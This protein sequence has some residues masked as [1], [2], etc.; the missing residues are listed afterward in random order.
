[1]GPT[2]LTTEEATAQLA[3]SPLLLFPQTQALLAQ[4]HARMARAEWRA[5]GAARV[6]H[7]LAALIREALFGAPN[8]ERW[9]FLSASADEWQAYAYV[10]LLAALAC[11]DVCGAPGPREALVWLAERLTAPG[12]PTLIPV[13]RLAAAS[14]GSDADSRAL[15]EVLNEMDTELERCLAQEEAQSAKIKELEQQQQRGSEEVERKLAE[16]ERALR[17]CKEET[18]AV[19]E[20]LRKR[21]AELEEDLGEDSDEEREEEPPGTEKPQLRHRNRLSN[22]HRPPRQPRKGLG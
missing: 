13:P 11:V 14:G 4:A 7:E 2:T 6:A 3:A 9:A 21:V 1:V 8:G 19:V 22:H 16:A 15:E 20:K 12:T 10:E 5:L 18:S 17:A